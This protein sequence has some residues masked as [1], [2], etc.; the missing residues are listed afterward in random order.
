MTEQLW[1]LL[2]Y[3][4][5][6][7]IL[8]HS[9]LFFV[10][11]AFVIIIH[12]VLYKTKTGKILFLLLFSLFFYYKSSGWFVLLLLI[13]SLVDYLTGFYIHRSAEKYK[14]R[15]GLI[16]SILVNLGFLGYFKYANF[17][18]ENV[19]YLTGKDM[20]LD[21]FLP[22]GISF[23]TFQTMSY[24]LDIYRGKLEPTRNFLDF[25]FY[26]SFFPQLVAGP[27]VRARE[28]LPQIRS[29]QEI[30]R[31]MLYTGIYRFIKGL[32][33]KAIFAD[34][35]AQYCDL[36]YANPGGFGGFENLMAMYG[37]TLQIYMDFSGYSDMAIGL[38]LMLGFKI[39]ENFKSPYVSKNV[40]EFWSRWHI[41]LSTWFRDYVYIPLG[42][43]RKGEFNMYLFIFI[44]FLVSGLWHGAHWKFVVWGAMH[45]AGLMVGRFFDQRNLIPKF[46]SNKFVAW[47]LTFQFV[48]VTWILF[49]SLSFADAM[50]SLKQI[51]F[52][53]DFAYA[54]PFFET[55]TLWVILLLIGF[56]FHFISPE[57]KEKIKGYFVSS[58]F[59]VKLVIILIILQ[60]FI[61]LRSET[62]KPFI[63]FQ[64]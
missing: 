16:I 5:D 25:A 53:M 23:F 46:I 11:F 38:S 62:V 30:T 28:F 13:S 58:P 8:F 1:D 40:G 29:Q 15:I 6:N 41:T 55:Y 31:E 47:F 10:L 9:E 36:V 60:I 17:V 20:Y 45:G 19:G 51:F 52:A 24:S 56:L 21:L 48:A 37:Y 50:T 18:L 12:A 3:N 35:I 43:N 33:K 59:F 61:Q 2:K 14:K 42:G 54:V 27:I 63:Y 22:V 26:V 39:P 64:F 57:I 7:P 49:R 4:P 34:F 32:I 44:T